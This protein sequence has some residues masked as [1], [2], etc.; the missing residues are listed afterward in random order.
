MHMRNC[1]NERSETE[2]F[3]TKLTF[4]G[5]G[6]KVMCIARCV[7]RSPSGKSDRKREK[8]RQKKEYHILCIPHW[9]WINS[10]WSDGIYCLMAWQKSER[11]KPERLFEMHQNICFD[12]KI[13]TF[14]KADFSFHRFIEHFYIR[15]T[16]ILF[17]F[18]ANAP[19]RGLLLLSIAN[20]SFSL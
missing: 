4:T 3:R 14:Y 2:L 7:A 8:K 19:F 18:C 11:E 17:A 1:A 12:R 9:N 20:F 15:F 13:Q 6:P 16:P 10:F 5:N